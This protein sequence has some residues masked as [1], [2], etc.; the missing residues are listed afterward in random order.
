MCHICME[1][2]VGYGLL[3]ITRVLCINVKQLF[4]SFKKKSFS[5]VLTCCYIEINGLWI[6]FSLT[7]SVCK[8]SDFGHSQ[9]VCDIEKGMFTQ[10]RSIA[11][12]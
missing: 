4:T 8:I 1:S 2:I 6:T 3:L 7:S 11:V 10:F 12:P 9:S 5:D